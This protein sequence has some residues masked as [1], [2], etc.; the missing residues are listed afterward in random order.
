ML[1]VRELTPQDDFQEVG[2]VYVK[3]WQSAYQGILPQRFLDKLT[4]DRWT[5]A[6]RADPSASLGL[7]LDGRLIG[8]SYVCFAREPGR[9]GYGEIVSIYLL[10][11]HAGRGYGR[12]LMEAAL[13]KLREN[14]CA[15][16]CLWALTQNVRAE[17][18]YTHMGFAR[19][20]RTMREAFGGSELE[21]SE[22]CRHIGSQG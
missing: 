14:G 19:S 13:A 11:E 8:T 18:F 20:G 3:S 16:V 15:D 21:L 1:I 12:P 6:L 10:P 7:Y 17:G 5:G 22:F 4:Q 2:C 9:E